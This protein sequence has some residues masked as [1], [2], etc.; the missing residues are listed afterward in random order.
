MQCF[1]NFGAVAEASEVGEVYRIYL[2]VKVVT[3]GVTTL[4]V[5][6]IRTTGAE[7]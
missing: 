2:I 5:D 6:L 1:P 4:M 3:L 7:P